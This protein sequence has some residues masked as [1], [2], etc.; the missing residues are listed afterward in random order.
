LLKLPRRFIL[1]DL[2][3][4]TW[5]GAAA[6]NWSGSGEHR[7]LVQLAAMLINGTEFT[8]LCSYDVLVKP[9]IN[10]TLSDYFVELTHI[11]QKMV[12]DFGHDFSRIIND[13][14]SWCRKDDLYCFDK[15]QNNR[16]FD[17]D[18]LIE[19]C[20]LYGLEF[21]FDPKKFHNV[22]EVF[23]RNGYVVKQSGAA[24]EAFG[25]K[26]PARPHNALNDVNG[27]VIA[28]NELNKRLK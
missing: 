21:P 5:E 4:T 19:N 22:N 3:C 18:V 25:L 28:L 12:D 16:L 11:T 15:V 27:L 7:E 1:F 17:R 20:D 13:F 23:A 14:Y 6:R 26:I 8:P 2:E 10:P 24:P 9:R